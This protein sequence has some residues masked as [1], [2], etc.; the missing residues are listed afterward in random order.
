MGIPA[1]VHGMT[2]FDDTDFFTDT[3]TGFGD[4]EAPTRRSPLLTG[5]ILVAAA[6]L[7]LGGMVWVKLAQHP[8]ATVTVDPTTALSVFARPQRSTDIVSVD[9]LAGSQIAADSTRFLVAT[10]TASYYAGVSRTNLVCVLAVVKGDLPTKSCTSADAGGRLVVNDELMVVTTGGT[11]P[12]TADGWH[13]AA[14]DV[15][16][17]D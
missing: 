7:V 8:V 6:A 14:P 16:V 4:R 15:F 11:A 9:D 17:N 2:T 3:F 5:L 13:E 12:A 10:P 1:D